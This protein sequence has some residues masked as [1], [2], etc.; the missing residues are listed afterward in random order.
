[1]PISKPRDRTRRAVLARSGNQCA[2]PSCTEPIYKSTGMVGQLAHIEGARPGSARHRASQPPEERH[3][4]SNL[5]CMCDPHG[6]LIDSDDGAKTYTVSALKRMKAEHEAKIEGAADR[7]WIKPPNSVVGGQFGD[8]PVHFWV[9]RQ[10]RTRVYSDDQ[11]AKLSELLR[12]SLDLSDL[13]T[14]MKTLRSM[15]SADVKALLQQSYAKVGEDA[16]NLYAHLAL[17]MSVAAEVTFGEFLH[18][19]VEGNDATGLLDV[20]AKRRQE[21]IEGN[22]SSFFRNK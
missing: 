12:L 18:F 6:T 9:D 16:Y 14:L 13:S 10:G 3:G 20:G 8:T 21:I 22:V 2:F 1:M 7:S 15:D 11:L 19:I 5:I 4:E 17:P